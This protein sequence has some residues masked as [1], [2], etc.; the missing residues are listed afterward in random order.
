MWSTGISELFLVCNFGLQNATSLVVNFHEEKE[1]L[2]NLIS[3]SN[4]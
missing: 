1:D 3:S 2:T 4:A